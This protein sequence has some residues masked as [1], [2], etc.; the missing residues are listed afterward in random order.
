MITMTFKFVRASDIKEPLHVLMAVSGASGTGKTHSAMRIAST[1]SKGKPF[2]VIDTEAGRARHKQSQF[3]FDHLDFTPFE[4]KELVGYPPE[5]YIAVI[6]AAEAAGYPVIVIDS[7]SHVWEGINGV[8][9]LHD[10]A[11]QAMASGDA[12]LMDKLS[13]AA[14]GKVKP[15][16]RKL[17][18]RLIQCR[19][20]VILCIRAKERV[21]AMRGGKMKYV[22]KSK[23]RREDLPFDI[24][25]DKDL[26]FEMTAS[27]LLMP[28]KVGVPVPLKL[29]DELVRAFPVDRQLSETAG[30]ILLKW[31]ESNGGATLG[32]KTII[33]K[34]RAEARKGFDAVNKFW[35]GLKDDDKDLVRPFLAELKRLADEAD[36]ATDEIPFE[37]E[38][39]DQ[40][41]QPE[42]TKSEA[43]AFEEFKRQRALELEGSQSEA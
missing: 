23:I 14:W 22:G 33:D 5:R 19:A 6:D 43:E 9:E 11:L 36:R 13:I 20:H 26:I 16:Y 39:D 7:F 24:A 15:R 28:E 12:A 4:K 32:D 41:V 21:G 17:L 27:F 30:D 2:C 35:K 37:R 31:S 34:A 38:D 10:Q 18:H 1:L 42:M 8:L 40:P 29:P 25:A 3:E